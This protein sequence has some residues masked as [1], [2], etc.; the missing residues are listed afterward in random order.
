MAPPLSG[1]GERVHDAGDLGFDRAQP[2]DT[3][4]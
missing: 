1:G 2:Y 3:I 4:G